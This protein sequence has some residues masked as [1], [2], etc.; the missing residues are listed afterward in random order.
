MNFYPAVF[1]EKNFLVN[2]HKKGGFWGTY[3]LIFTLLVRVMTKKLLFQILTIYAT[4]L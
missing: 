4:K 2:T 1:A 3:P